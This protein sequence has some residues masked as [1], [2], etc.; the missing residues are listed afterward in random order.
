M[1]ASTPAAPI[2]GHHRLVS[3]TSSPE[4]PSVPYRPR[5]AVAD[6]EPIDDFDPDRAEAPSF[7]PGPFAA[8]LPRAQW[9]AP[10]GPPVVQDL[11]ASGWDTSSAGAHMVVRELDRLVSADA[12]WTYVNSIPGRKH[13]SAIDHL[14]VGPS[15]VFTVNA[16]LPHNF[17]GWLGGAVRTGISEA[18]RA[19][20][21]LTSATRI[22][23]R[24]RG[25][26][27]LVSGSQKPVKQRA[28][29]V[30]IVNHVALVT[31]LLSQ[32]EYLDAST[33]AR[34]L[35]HA[36]LGSTWTD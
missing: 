23:V 7:R 36:R 2:A 14:V 32:P 9:T 18:Q 4:V 26:I 16:G 30:E 15:G 19:T 31:F 10:L 22:S 5:R 12:R 20:R 6:L 27:V 33:R 3:P 29:T 28:N 34:I 1:T 11:A 13:G 21:L 25:L 8:S 24:V 35:G 17:Q